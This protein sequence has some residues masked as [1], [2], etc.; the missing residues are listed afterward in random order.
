MFC[1]LNVHS[2]SSRMQGTAPIAAL[3]DR[4]KAYGMTQLALTEVNGLWGFINFTRIA[5]QTGIQAICGS[6]ILT[7]PPKEPPIQDV[8]LL[9]ET[10]AGYENLCRVLSQLHDD[11]ALD[12]VAALQTWGAGL[13]LLCPDPMLL[14]RL[15]KVLPSHNLFG[16]LRPGIDTISLLHVCQELDIKTVATGEVYF[17]EP[18]DAPLYGLLRAI[19]RNERLSDLPQWEIKSGSHYFAGEEEI[20][21]RY[22]HCPEV[23]DYTTQLADRCKTDWNFTSTVFPSIGPEQ[24]AVRQLHTRVYEGAAKRYSTPLSQ[25]VI[26]RIERE[27]DLICAKG[28]APYFLIV[29]DIVKQSKMTIGRGSGA[30][31]IVSYCLYIT[32]VDPIRYNLAFERFLNPERSDM[33]DI[34]VD[35]P[36]DERDEVLAYVFGKYGKDKAAMVA[37]QVLLQPRSAV[38]EVGKV[39][40]L[41]NEEI[42]AVTRRIR[43]LFAES[44]HPTGKDIFPL[45][46]D[47]LP[48][49][50]ASLAKEHPL[51]LDS[52][53]K[54]VLQRAMRLLGVFHYPSVHSGGVVIVPD[55]IRRYVPVL[56][57][58]KGVPIVE[59]EKDQVEDAGL[60]KIDLLGNRSLAVVRDC[61][62]YIN[63]YRLPE[64]HLSYHDIRP[65]ENAKT[66]ALMQSGH[67]MG[68]FYIES[69][70]TRQLLAKAGKVDFEHVVIYSSIIRPAANR[71]IDDI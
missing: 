51:H 34:D 28:F 57:A 59:W 38:R 19:D 67:T 3:V 43:L 55:E 27:L 26:D 8:V 68:I 32:Q 48:L 15:A 21:R 40:G 29:R 69:P 56:Q 31:S 1:H 7:G 12:I 16:E 53:L 61:L 44:G 9:V 50:T 45:R 46:H 70:A 39:Y 30:A 18:E 24:E 62:H 66:R 42:L 49:S 65:M 37:N 71:L 23:V 41:S 60:V 5:K 14:Q 11:S 58:P 17:L 4:A 47:P 64:N 52:T 22:P 54:E 36:W 20:R 10:Q 6:H 35:F 13:I 2:H 63:L 25:K 33:P